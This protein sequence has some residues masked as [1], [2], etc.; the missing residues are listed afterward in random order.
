MTILTGFTRP[1][2][3]VGADLGPHIATTTGL[4]ITAAT[5]DQTQAIV[6]GTISESNRA[7]IQGAINSYAHNP[8]HAVPTEDI[9]LSALRTK[10]QA[11]FNQ[12]DTFTAGQIQRLVAALVLRATR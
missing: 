9:D 4:P 3:P 10:A 5:V 6:H 12:T 11:V 2:P 1:A 8:N 7:A